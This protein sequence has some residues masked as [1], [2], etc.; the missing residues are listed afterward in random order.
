MPAAP[1]GILSKHAV[2]IVAVC[3]LLTIIFAYT[4]KDLRL[5]VSADALVLENDQSLQVY[6]DIVSRY[7]SD[8]FLVVTFRP[9]QALF[10]ESSL[11][12]LQNL[13][14]QLSELDG[15]VDVYSILNVPLL[16]SPRLS[17][18]ELTRPLPRLKDEAV[19]LDL[20]K[21]ELSTSP[22]YGNRLLSEDL[23]TTAIQINLKADEALATLQEERQSLREADVK[24]ALSPEQ[25]KR[26]SVVE[27]A[28]TQRLQQQQAAQHDLI[29]KLRA[30]LNQY[31]NT[32][33][34]SIAGLPLIVV[35]MMNF[36]RSDI[37]TFSLLVAISMAVLLWWAF[38]TIIWV[39]LPLLCVT[40]S[41]LWVSGV[42]SLLGWPVTAI[43]ANY[44]AL[45]LIFGLSLQIHLVVQFRELQ[46]QSPTS[47]SSELLNETL[48]LKFAPSVYTILTT[49]IA[50]MALVISDIRPVIDFGKMM[51]I[52]LIINLLI[53]FTLFPALIV[54]SRRIKVPQLRDW[55]EQL[56]DFAANLALHRGRLIIQATLVLGALSVVGI[57]QLSV[58]NRF[59]DYFDE[60]TDIYRGMVEVDQYLGGTTPMDIL[61]RAPKTIAV[62]ENDQT[63][64]NANEDD[65]FADNP[66][67]ADP[68]SDDTAA[69]QTT[70]PYWLRSGQLSKLERLHVFF[71]HFEDT[72]KVLSLY[73]TVQTLEQLNKRQTL[74]DFFLSLFYQN[75]TPEL[76]ATLIAP[77]LS[78][79]GQELRFSIRVYE[80]NHDLKRD[81][82]IHRIE[83]G[84]IEQFDL[85][86]E[87]F[88]ISGMMV[89]YNNLLQ[90]LFD[91]QIKTLSAVFAAIFVVFI[92]LFRSVKV[93]LIALAP[94]ILS[95]SLILGIIGFSGIPLDLMT[96][97]VAGI[98]VG[99][100]VDD[101]IHYLHRLKLVWKD[102]QNYETAIRD[103]HRHIGKAMF[104]TSITISLGFAVMMFS[105]F[106]PTI[107]FGLFTAAAMLIAM[108]CNMTLLPRLMFI[109]KPYKS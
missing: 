109:F 76:H 27:T 93:A 78:Q 103:A 69:P 2:T 79:D 10:G 13:Q 42:I 108:L 48:R 55:T 101:T 39:V 66:F 98:A 7:D 58:D 29:V 28:Y 92:L 45:L 34:I 88:N 62:K 100:A 26:L 81:E 40:V 61:I 57:T 35:D 30:I 106:S 14:R 36:I 4:S 85:Q 67:G 43:S 5:E 71:E 51:V 49:I 1:I 23:S 11:Q 73:N 6:R 15:V 102:K 94:N 12:T 21:L 25:S 83:Q 87:R 63:T 89:L 60:Q 9:H 16:F 52:A 47:S 33:D 46:A 22:L 77:Y 50:F 19:N 72:G 18:T 95:A 3:A 82:L 84:L 65:P 44:I 70:L 32:A 37:Q 80:T 99:I 96:I 24:N 91:S 59:I 20:A 86:P 53:C 97:T 75:L 105:N 56:M 107:Y 8:E 17:L 31:E 38:K 54:L 68:F 104:Y 41:A 64:N 90:S 74:D